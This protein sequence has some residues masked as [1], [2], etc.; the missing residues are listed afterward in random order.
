MWFSFKEKRGIDY[1]WNL[2]DGSYMIERESH[3]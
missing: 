1:G 2:H 3:T